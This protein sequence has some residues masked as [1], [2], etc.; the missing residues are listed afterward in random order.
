MRLEVVRCFTTLS[1]RVKDVDR[2][3]LVACEGDDSPMPS[4]RMN[5]IA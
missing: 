2:N 5:E 1:Q 3:S 4:A